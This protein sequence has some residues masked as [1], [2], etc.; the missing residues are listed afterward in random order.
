[1][2][3]HYTNEHSE[4]TLPQLAL[5]QYFIS[6]FQP[7]VLVLQ[8]TN[9][10]VRSLGYEATVEPHRTSNMY[11]AAIQSILDGLRLRECMDKFNFDFRK[12]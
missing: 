4:S 1:M 8:A 11:T 6:C 9:T 7:L 2:E 10:G 3:F 5:Q 12:Y